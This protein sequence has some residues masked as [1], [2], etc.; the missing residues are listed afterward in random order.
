MPSCK[1]ILIRPKAQQ[2]VEKG[3]AL[4]EEGKIQEAKAEAESA[5]QLDSSFTAAID[6]QLKVQEESNR[7]QAIAEWLQSSKQRLAEGMPEEAETLLAKMLELEPSNRQAKSLLT[8]VASEKAERQTAAAAAGKD[9]GGARA[10]DAAELRSVHHAAHRSAE[11]ISE[12]RRNPAAAG[13][14]A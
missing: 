1:R 8:Q 11:G 7:A 3:R 6:L 14:G 12:R 13:Y 9:A 2:H 10:L 4:L 5:L